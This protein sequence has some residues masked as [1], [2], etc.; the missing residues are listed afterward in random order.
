SKFNLWLFAL[1][2]PLGV[3]YSFLK[4]LIAVLVLVAALVFVYFRVIRRLPRLTL[5]AEGLV[6]LG[7]IIA[8]M[9]A[10]I[11]YDGA[12]LARQGHSALAGPAGSV[13][14]WVLSGLP[15][16]ALTSLALAGFWAHSTLVLIFLNILPYSKHFHIITA[17][18][19]VFFRDL[20]PRGR[21]RPIEDIEGRIE[22]SEPLGISRIEQFTWKANLDFYTCTECGRCS[23]NC[24]ATRTGKLL[25]PKHFGLDLRDHLYAREKELTAGGEIPAVE[26]VPDTIKPEVLW[27]CT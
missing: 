11:L 8:M 13:A 10:D 15:E 14:G 6:I 7:I 2:Q 24:P 20:T 12:V 5:N 9:V 17:I 4:D 16:G 1:D 25:S 23:D 21:L 27:A 26:L 22:R 3:V 18:P 19:N